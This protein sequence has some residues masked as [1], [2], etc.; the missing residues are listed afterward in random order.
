MFYS[1]G[2]NSGIGLALVKLIVESL[3]ATLHV[4]SQQGGDA[5]TAFSIHFKA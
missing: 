2:A 1:G 5:F 3:G 4:S